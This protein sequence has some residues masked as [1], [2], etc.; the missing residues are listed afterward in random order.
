MS[1]NAKRRR[2]GT[3][4]RLREQPAHKAVAPRP[5]LEWLNNPHKGGPPRDLFILSRP[6]HPVLGSSRSDNLALQFILSLE[7]RSP[8]GQAEQPPKVSES[9][10]NIS[11]FHT[12]FPSI[13]VILYVQP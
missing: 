11:L 8:E 5:G 6:P 9:E 10:Y 1:G 13:I 4:T 3:K 7:T 12:R 2:A